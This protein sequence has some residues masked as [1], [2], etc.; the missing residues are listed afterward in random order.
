VELIISVKISTGGIDYMIEYESM[1]RQVEW[2][3]TLKG[4]DISQSD[5]EVIIKF[6]LL[7]NV[8]E[9]RLFSSRN[10]NQILEKMCSDLLGE[11][12]FKKNEYDEYG[13]FFSNRYIK[14]GKLTSRFD[15]LEIASTYRERAENSL[16]DFHNG[17]YNDNLFLTY[18][19]IA[20]RFRNNLF[21]GSKDAMGL[22]K[23]ISCFE[24]INWMLHKLLS[25]MVI[26]RF[27]GLDKKY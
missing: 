20:Y 6:L 23:Y 18:L 4:G 7:F 22:N 5:Q 9:A 21:H 14:N 1:K 13:R 15:S 17:K 26:N 16:K 25:D 11:S 19:L 10:T 12:W 2:A 24:K 3:Y 27:E 8:F